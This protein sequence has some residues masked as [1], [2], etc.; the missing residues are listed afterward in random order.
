MEV[1]GKGGLHE[2]AYR[3]LKEGEVYTPYVPAETVIP[4]ITARS[5]IIGVI[6]AAIFTLATA[7]AGLRAGIVFEA[8]IPIAILAIGVGR[9]FRRKNTILE[10]VIIQSI[11]AASGLVVAG[12]IFTLPTLFMLDLQPSL[13]EVFLAALFGGMLGIL[14][15][16]P[17]RK[18]FVTDLHGQLPFPEATATTEILVT[19]EKAGKGAGTLAIA[20]LVGGIFEFLADGMRLWGT[21]FNWRYFGGWFENFTERTKMLFQLESTPLFIGLGYIVGI[22]YATIIVMGSFTAWFVLV[23]L[24]GYTAGL[25]PD[26]ALVIGDKTVAVGELTPEIIFSNYVRYIGIGAI[27]AAG[28][29]G[30][31]KNMGVIVSSFGVGFRGIFGRRK[32]DAGTLPRT[33]RDISMTAV[34]GLIGLVLV[35]TAVFFY[36]ITGSMYYML[37][38]LLIAFVI[39]FLFTTVAARAIAIVGVNPVSGMTLMTLILSSAILVAAG[40]SGESGM[41]I[42]LVIGGVVCTALSMS[43]GFVTD[44][45]IGYWL[46]SSPFQQERWKFLGTI[47]AAAIVGLAMLLIH[48]AFGFTIEDPTTGKMIPNPAMPAPQA[49]VMKTVIEPLMSPEADIPW[50]LFGMGIVVALFMNWLKVPA[51]AFGLGMYLPQQIN[52]PLLLGAFAAYLL[53]K[54]KNKALGKA[55]VQKG[56]L[57]ASGFIAGAALF[58]ILEAIL[59]V[60]PS[61]TVLVNK[62]GHQVAELG[63]GVKEK[64][65]SLMERF[66][67]STGTY[68]YTGADGNV[69][70]DFI[71]GAHDPAT[72][73]GMG[74]IVLLTGWLFFNAR[75]TKAEEEEISEAEAE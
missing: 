46:G 27:A 31:I 39:S 40:L 54:G 64:T 7:V 36:F 17:L 9:M 34:L 11:G 70:N 22:R 68:N 71:F 13:L 38:G 16:I 30:V 29:L 15:L 28:I 23:P 55:R 51:L 47:I 26:A 32:E 8:A 35:G 2:S 4:E 3:P 12:A 18:M 48:T 19:G 37:L 6:M 75:R 45:K 62:A 72:L 69:T 66:Y 61:G 41:F 33:Q 25:F 52:T 10:N 50:L 42:A 53:G 63:A 73:L 60:V 14:F 44:L 20:V 67:Y 56:T 24:F 59:R 58:K 74:L 1:S 57:I 43:G 5:V 21:H 49:N 65:V